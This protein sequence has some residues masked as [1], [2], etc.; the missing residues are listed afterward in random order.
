MPGALPPHEVMHH[1]R[2][3]AGGPLALALNGGL[4][5][6]GAGGGGGAPSP[7]L[8]PQHLLVMPNSA[9]RMA[10]TGKVSVWCYLVLF[11]VTYIAAVRGCNV[12]LDRMMHHRHHCH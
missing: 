2:A 3:A 10:D 6:A 9:D 11:C 7:P 12:T 1:G 8:P 4:T 5:A